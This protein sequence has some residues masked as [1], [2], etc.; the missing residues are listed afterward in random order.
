MVYTAHTPLRVKVVDGSSFKLLLVNLGKGS[1]SHITFLRITPKPEHQPSLPLPASSQAGEEELQ[2][3]HNR[4]S[5]GLNG[6]LDWQEDF[7]RVAHRFK[8]LL[9]GKTECWL[10][11]VQQQL[12]FC[13]YKVLVQDW[14][15]WLQLA[16]VHRSR[17]GEREEG[18]HQVDS[19]DG[20]HCCQDPEVLQ[21]LERPDYAGQ[22][23]GY[24]A[25]FC[26]EV[27]IEFM[28]VWTL[29]ADRSSCMSPWLRKMKYY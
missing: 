6:G 29:K 20:A 13:L 26:Q 15:G 22:G 9:A 16:V 25:V 2:N 7:L 17:G 21:F 3:R 27:R 10:G 19:D 11:Y 8:S 14:K 1:T 12:R 28:S 4:S 23:I 24:V 5:V 18:L